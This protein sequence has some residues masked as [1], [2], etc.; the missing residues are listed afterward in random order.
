MVLG[1]LETQHGATCLTATASPFSTF[2]S[3]LL[4]FH[5]LIN[6]ASLTLLDSHT[7]QEPQ[8]YIKTMGFKPFRDTYLQSAIS[9]TLLNHILPKTGGRGRGERPGHRCPVRR[10]VPAKVIRPYTSFRLSTVNCQ[11][12]ATRR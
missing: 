10:K 7:S 9:Q 6:S 5:I 12:S 4:S 3:Q 8:I 11:L 2:D 1:R